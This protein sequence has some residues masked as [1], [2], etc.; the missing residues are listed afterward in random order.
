MLQ[1]LDI[2]CPRPLGW[3]ESRDGNGNLSSWFMSEWV[4]NVQDA[5]RWL[6][7]NLRHQPPERRLQ[8]AREIRDRLFSLYDSGCYHA[9]TKTGNMLLQHPANDHDRRWLWID[10]DVLSVDTRTTLRRQIRNLVQLNGSIDRHIDR[11]ERLMY[12]RLFAQLNRK[13]SQ[14][15]V[16]QHIEKRTRERLA[17]ER[18]S[19]CGP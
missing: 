14:P 15:A 8:L 2:G 6:K 4:D 19:R 10:L 1:H 17:H 18:D 3:L 12:L 7:R 11:D 13:L 9:D 16:A 5:G